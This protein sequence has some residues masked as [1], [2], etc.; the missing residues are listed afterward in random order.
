M[1]S[2][3][4]LDE[5][6]EVTGGH[7]I[8]TAQTRVFDVTHDSRQV[9]QGTLFVAIQ[10]ANFDGH[11]FVD[12][13]VERGASGV[14]VNNPASTEVSQLI[15]R[16]TR[17]ALG[18]LAAEIHDRP[19]DSI[20]VIGVTGTNGKTT[21]TH[22]I[23]S[24][25]TSVGIP[26]GMIGTLGSVVGERVIPSPRTTPEASDFQRTL[27]SMRDLGAV[28]VAVEV[29]SHALELKRVE[30]TRFAVAAF[31]NLSQDHLDFHGNMADYQRAKERLFEEFVIE[32]AVVNVDDPVGAGIAEGYTGELVRVGE[33]GEFRFS[34]LEPN[35][36]G[37]SFILHS[38]EGRRSV[39]LPI[40]GAFNISNF[41][42][43]V[44]CVYASGVELD[45]LWPHLESVQ[46][47][48]GRFEI[49]SLEADDG[50]LPR[51][52]VDY[53]HTPEGIE[54]AVETGREMTTGRVIVV[55]GAGGDRDGAKRPLMGKAASGADVV[56]ITSD[57]PRSED[58]EAIIDDIVAGGDG[59]TLRVS[60]RRQAI[61]TAIGMATADDLV[62]VLG[63]GH[64]SGQEIAGVV[65][66]FDDADVVRQELILRRKSTN[67]D[68][69]SGTIDQ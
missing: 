46:P 10:G 6:A 44:A 16:D 69:N 22:F 62:M 17:A 55:F 42:L 56:I 57:N 61:A 25:L 8:G 18:Q 27:A 5:L 2:S 35:R 19:S 68:P 12:Q 51:A 41:V 63:K 13:A 43:A 26:T 34:D 48:P 14:C 15:V 33:R 23:H 53:A 49:V 20:D 29:S 54:K 60:E 40:F 32:T 7:V 58:P 11:D 30:A 38:P 21:V 3:R 52:I 1:V 24:L 39:Q 28:K 9:D 47:V 31:T 4:A 66:P 59:P 37:N 50:S 64:E 45:R 65:Y 36:E 67:F